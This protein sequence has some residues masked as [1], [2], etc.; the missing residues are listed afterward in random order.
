VKHFSNK[1]TYSN[2]VATLALFLVIAGGSAFAASKLGKN[3]VGTKQLKNNAVTTA[4]IK[5]EAVT[6]PKIKLSTLGTVPSATN[7]TTA[8][9]AGNAATLGGQPPSTFAKASLWAL[10]DKG[11]QIVHQSGGITVTHNGSV[12][13]VSFPI[14]LTG[15]AVSATRA[16]TTSDTGNSAG[17]EV[18]VCG[19]GL[20]CVPLGLA[21]DEK[22]ALVVT[23]ELEA[24]P[25]LVNGEHAFWI[26][27]N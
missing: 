2:V 26:V 23:P 21:N 6:G 9:N 8:A 18:G 3:S 17:V 4:K 7:A 11:G 20:N 1:L 27:A 24:G 14:P 16:F 12:Y 13:Q 25:S 19:I 10:V 22:N 15:Q 5:K